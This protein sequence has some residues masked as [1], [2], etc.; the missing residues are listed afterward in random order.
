MA[1]GLSIPFV[2]SQLRGFFQS[3]LE[4]SKGNGKS[5]IS[6]DQAVTNPASDSAETDAGA[7]LELGGDAQLTPKNPGAGGFQISPDGT[8]HFSR[9]RL[10]AS[11]DY[12][13]SE[14]TIQ[15]SQTSD[16]SS[17]FASMTNLEV[18]MSVSAEFEEALIQTGR[19]QGG[20]PVTNFGNAAR[21]AVER[22][23]TQQIRASMSSSAFHSARPASRSMT[24]AISGGIWEPWLEMRP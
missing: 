3:F 13:L 24:P 23:K 15:T 2:S 20:N 17:V 1:Q 7:V 14:A 21:Q 22:I 4:E 16:G 5:A 18:S 9:T 10:S 11:L 12:S 6:S 19:T 8:Y